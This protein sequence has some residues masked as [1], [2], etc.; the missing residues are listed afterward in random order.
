MLYSETAMAI[1][2]KGLKTWNHPLRQ[3]SWD[4]WLCC[5]FWYITSLCSGV[6]KYKYIHAC[7]HSLLVSA[8]VLAGDKQHQFH[9]DQL[10]KFGGLGPNEYPRDIRCIW[11]WLFIEKNIPRVFPA[12]SKQ[13]QWNNYTSW[14]WNQPSW[15]ILVKMGSSSPSS[16]ENETKYLKHFE[17][18][19]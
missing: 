19:T 11:A 7:I 8:H 13:K 9:W 17:T 14:W 18:T 16:G 6:C 1:H 15:K 5:L 12:F 10:R 3:I 4:H 2:S